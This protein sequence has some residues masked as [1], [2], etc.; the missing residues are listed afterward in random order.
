L[1][2]GGGGIEVRIFYSWEQIGNKGYLTS[3]FYN[4]EHTFSFEM[5]ETVIVTWKTTKKL[6]Q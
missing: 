2:G 5:S 6:G 4:D 1:F 3:A